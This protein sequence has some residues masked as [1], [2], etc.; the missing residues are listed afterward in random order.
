MVSI[1]ASVLGSTIIEAIT[2]TATDAPKISKVGGK[3]SLYITSTKA[4]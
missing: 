3:P 4:K 2:N 1:I